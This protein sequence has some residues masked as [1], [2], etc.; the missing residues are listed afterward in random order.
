[1]PGSAPVTG[2]PDPAAP[3]TSVAS[4]TVSGT[5]GERG[6]VTLEDGTR[7]TLAADDL[8][9]TGLRAGDPVDV[10]MRAI[11]V[12]GALLWEAREAALRLLSHRARARGELARRLREK[13]TPAGLVARTLDELEERGYLDDAAFARAW[14]ADRLRLRPRGRRVLLSELRKKGVADGVAREA[15]DHAFSAH[16]ASDA[17]IAGDLAQGWL[18]RQ[19]PRVRE[20]L[21]AGERT[22]ERE[23]ALRRYQ[24]FM[25]RRGIAG[26]LALAALDGERSRE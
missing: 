15:V 10:Q 19:P 17:R 8:L 2:S 6:E 21:L 26:G 12:E 1:M 13:G 20:A 4:L 7:L 24:G 16:Q 11:L 14:V 22:P 9:A 3:P 25:A 23:K 18:R 5:R